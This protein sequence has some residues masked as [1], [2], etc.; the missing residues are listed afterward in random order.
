LKI[1]AKTVDLI[2]LD[3]F[4]LPY[5]GSRKNLQVLLPLAFPSPT[6]KLNATKLSFQLATDLDKGK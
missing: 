5:L 3:A 1:V 2:S 4:T 6:G